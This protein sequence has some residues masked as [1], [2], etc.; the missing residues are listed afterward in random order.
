MT[1]YTVKPQ[2][3]PSEPWFDAGTEAKLIDDYRL[4]K[5]PIDCGLFEGTK[6]GK[7]DQEVCP[8]D[9]FEEVGK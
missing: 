4:E 8:F 3:D 9:E 1:K 6:D 5:T 7:I 2:N